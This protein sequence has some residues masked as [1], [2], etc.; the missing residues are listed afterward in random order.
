V[1]ES[2]TARLQAVGAPADPSSEI[3]VLEAR[4]AEAR[5]RLDQARLALTGPIRPRPD[6]LRAE[7]PAS[8]TQEQLW[9]LERF[10]PGLRA[11]NIPF[12]LRLRGTL[13]VVALER[14]LSR[15]IARHEALRTS[16][17][18]RNGEPVQVI[19]PG[20]SVRLPEATLVTQASL[21]ARL[22]AE[23]RAPF[24]ITR[25]PLIRFG[26]LSLAPDDH[27]LTATMHHICS[28][29]WSAS[30][31]LTELTELY[32]ADVEGRDP[33]L[34]ELSL[35]YQDFAA[36]QRDRLAA[37]ALE[38]HLR[39]WEQQ[40]A[41]L[42][43]LEFPADRPRPPAPTFSGAVI[44]HELPAGLIAELRTLARTNSVS[45]FMVLMSAFNV[46]LAR[47]TGQEDLVTG[48]ATS[49][50][51]RAE[52][53]P[54]IGFFTN[55]VVLRTDL[56]GDPAFREVLTRVRDV[57]LAAS[58]HQG[59]PFASVVERV[60]PPR[61]PARNPLF[62]VCFG[63]LPS[64]MLQRIEMPGLTGQIITGDMDSARFDIAINVLETGTSVT[65]QLEYASDLF[66]RWR[67]E[68]LARHLEAVLGAVAADPG[69][70][71]SQVGLLSPA[72]RE[73]VLDRWQGEVRGYR[74]ELVHALVAGQAAATPGGEAVT[75]AG[76]SLSYAELEQRAG[77]VAG[78]LRGLGAGAGDVAG[79]ALERGLWVPV[80]LLGVL[81]AGAA[82]APLELSHPADRLEWILGDC[83]AKVI[84]TTSDAAGGLPPG[85]W[86]VVC[87]DEMDLSGPAPALDEL[88]TLDSAAY[89]LYTSGSTGRPKGVTIEHHALATYID[90]LGNVFG[91][92]PGDRML[93]FSSLI[94]D[95]SEGELFTGLSRGATVVL[96]PAEATVDPR[97]LSALMREQRVSYLGAP[98][99]MIALLDPEPY[100]ALR[101]MLVGGE[102]FSGDLVNR[103]N[104]P[105]RLFLNAYGP[106]EATIGCTFYPCEHKEWAASP[107][108]GRAMP[109]RR[110]YLLDRWDNPVPPGVPG[111]IVAA[112]EGLARGYLGNPE[113][114][115]A[116]FTPDPFVPG[117]R[118]YR[119]G[120][121]G[122]WTPDGQIQF[123]GRRDTQI[124][125]RGQRIELE[126]IETALAAVPGVS[127]A[128]AV[129]R[130]D[131]PGGDGIA[132]YILPAPGA[133]PPQAA[134]LREHLAQTLPAYMI[135]AAY[136]T[137]DTLPLSPTGKV[138][139][140][141]LPA[142]DPG[143]TIH[144]PYTPPATPAQ[145]LIATIYADILGHPRIGAHD[146]FFDLGG[147]SLQAASV[148]DRVAELTGAQVPLRQFFA[149]PTVAAIAQLA[150]DGAQATTV[151]APFGAS[152]AIVPLKATG[153]RP[154]LFCLPQV[155]GS[156]YTY[157]AI[158]RRIGAEQPV[159]AFEAPGLEDDTVPLD[160]VEGLA[161]HYLT[162]LLDHRPQGPYQLVGYSMGAL[163]AF[164]MALR[165]TKDGHSVALALIDPSI[166]GPAAAI[167]PSQILQ[168]FTDNLAAMAGAP[169]PSL[170]E[171]AG[172]AQTASASSEAT[173]YGEATT[174][175]DGLDPDALA[176]LLVDLRQ[177]GLVPA[178]LSAAFLRR[179][180][181][182]YSANAR[183]LAAYQ[184]PS[185][186]DGR[187]TL[188]RA[189]QSP[190]SGTFWAHW[191]V[192]LDDVVVPGDHFTI[193]HEPNVATLAGALR[194]H[195]GEADDAAE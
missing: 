24:D 149:A 178:G 156:P 48:T 136:V 31:L 84:L 121:L 62:Q 104:L 76:E 36:W 3:G 28:D 70:R 55:M 144:A 166:P 43:T 88:A 162:A 194:Q 119:T 21:P 142:P 27:V 115:E 58:E 89:V 20:V 139:R 192:G 106:T 25:G 131:L 14:S 80:A 91:F 148:I 50:R 47:Y 78:V 34:P 105:G 35:Q 145:H 38:D 6:Y 169:A 103:W 99:A 107:P 33:E 82:F 81:K 118:A 159:L 95:L 113:L 126:E 167:P 182:V 120:D 12:G 1:T 51:D 86:D 165:L 29:G 164:D 188:I 116:K 191:A 11:Y 19:S 193:W 140:A 189:A 184:P 30:L 54:I 132:A 56:S 17:Q 37:G 52:L 69:L 7:A 108:I 179:R 75:F 153:S 160:T 183:A 109:N 127:Q 114:T 112:G 152:G 146:N 68:G 40:L 61:D 172:T 87:L 92:G 100:P 101:G 15:I 150:Q 63:L 53:E 45:L 130:H 67:M 74:R 128:V 177:R 8:A 110:V 10:A 117:D 185:P 171:T 32:A 65:V 195:L 60:R 26:L 41:A 13:D 49:G 93:Q 134:A 83:G 111:E 122:A 190:D 137:L 186:F 71:V 22:D 173:T 2:S 151:G 18:A 158:T 124:K 4:L 180:L 85:G 73:L 174:D 168:S 129:L 135:P 181:A 90:F 123:L 176:R 72:E 59:V 102:A 154:P 98:P 66:D 138:D 175:G 147:N 143:D 170:A 16:V 57:T 77:I 157:L 187:I 155:S 96:V 94:F 46:V 39:Y 64:Q 23:A 9:F 141:A 5:R 161:A 42:P 44:Y 125:L 133:R 163:V 79:V 97:E